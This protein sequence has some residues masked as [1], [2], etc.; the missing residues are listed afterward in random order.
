LNIAIYTFEVKSEELLGFVVSNKWIEV[1]L[2]KIKVIKKWQHPRL[3]K[4]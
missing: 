2:D 1:E 3:R 4:K